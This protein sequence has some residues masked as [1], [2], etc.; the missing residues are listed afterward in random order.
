[1]VGIEL[2]MINP[3]FFFRYLKVRCHDIQICGK[4]V[5]KLPTPCTYRSVIPKRVGYRYFNV[6][7]NSVNDASILCENFVKFGP[8]FCELKWIENENCTA[9]R[10]KFHDFRSKSIRILQF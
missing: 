4:I 3:T 10:P 8:A 5:A 9:T 2:Q 6:H 1:M 7:I